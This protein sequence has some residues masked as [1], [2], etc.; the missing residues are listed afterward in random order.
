MASA[1]ATKFLALISEDFS[2]Q[3]GHALP[4]GA[5]V[6]RGGINFSIYARHATRVML[7]FFLP[8]EDQEIAA[9][10]LDSQLNR[11]GDVWHVFVAGLNP[12]IQYGYKIDGPHNQVHRYDNT[13]IVADPYAIALNGRGKWADAGHS[14]SPFR[15]AV[16]VPK[17]YDWEFDQPLNRPLADSIIYELHIR[18]FSQDPSAHAQHPGTFR[19]LIEKIPYLLEL[20][21]TA[22]EL[23]PVTEFDELDNTRSHP[24]T[25]A[26][27]HNLWG[28]HPLSFFALKAAYGSGDALGSEINDFKDMVKALHAAGI[29]VI[30][31]VVYNHSGEGDHRGPTYSFKGIDNS[32]YYMLSEH[33]HYMNFSGCG[34]TINCN[35]P[36]VRNFIMD[37]LRYWV[38]DMHV[39]GFRFDLASIL[40]RDQ[41]GRVLDSPPLLEQIAA[42]PILASTKLIAEA[43]DAAGLYQVGSFPNWGRW[44]EWNGHFRDDVRHFVKGDPG[45]VGRLA[46]RLSG[47]ADLY[48]FGRDPGHGINF[49]TSH[50]GFTLRDLVSYN[51]KHNW[52]NGEHNNDGDNH[53]LSWNCGAEGESADPDIARLRAQQVRN[54]ATL[55]LVSRGVPMILAGDEFGRSQQGNNNSYCQDNAMSWLNWRDLAINQSLFRFF[56]LLIAFR[57][58]HPLLRHDSFAIKDGLGLQIHWHGQHLNAP[59]WGYESRQIA[60]HFFG[61]SALGVAPDVYLIANAHWQGANFQLPNLNNQRWYRFVD[62]N[63]PGDLAIMDEAHMPAL[64]D[65]HHYFVAART[66]V[67]LVAR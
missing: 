23:L 55:L 51:D 18:S 59:D 47:S 67:V 43:W 50:D 60:A 56:R 54:L 64:T 41:Q 25:G 3:R 52:A 49:V 6:E 30:L 8:D 40:G 12:G 32:T 35:Q 24:E 1:S 31:D 20:G 48:Q 66:T 61:T 65:P 46:N 62:T 14:K 7:M 16:L 21:I 29:E 28:Y 2:I 10:P 17:D 13:V 22:V 4:F 26:A 37:S 53:N 5:T 27:L 19:G 63:L 44:A 42:D 9:F 38:M 45:F 33:G 58:S 11:T 57:K 15:R 34:N 36:Y 39:D